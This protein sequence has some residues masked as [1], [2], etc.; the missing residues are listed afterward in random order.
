MFYLL[1][2]L[3]LPL[4]LEYKVTLRHFFPLVPYGLCVIT[5][6]TSQNTKKFCKVEKISDDIFYGVT[7]KSTTAKPFALTVTVTGFGLTRPP[8]NRLIV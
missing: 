8:P 1:Q 2:A 3:I 5:A 7:T 6:V 4:G